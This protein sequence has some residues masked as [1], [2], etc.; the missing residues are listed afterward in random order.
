MNMVKKAIDKVADAFAH[1]KAVTRVR[2]FAPTCLKVKGRVFSWPA[3]AKLHPFFGLKRFAF[4]RE[5]C[6]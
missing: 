5:K 1:D 6:L 2:M 3:T 4:H